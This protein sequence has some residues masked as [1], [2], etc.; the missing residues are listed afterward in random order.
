MFLL[1][2]LVCGW[3]GIGVDWVVVGEMDRLE[4]L[5]VRLGCLCFLWWGVFVKDVWELDCC[6]GE[7]G[8]EFK[9]GDVVLCLWDGVKRGVVGEESGCVGWKKML[10]FVVMVGVCGSVG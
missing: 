3:L 10:W 7:R 2:L 8:F 1:L 6:Y 9:G 4:K 5:F